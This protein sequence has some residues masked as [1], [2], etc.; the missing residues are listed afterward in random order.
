MSSTFQERMEVLRQAFAASLDDDVEEAWRLLRAGDRSAAAD[1]IHR[2]AG[3]AGTFGAPRVSEAAGHIEQLLPHGSAD[4][5]E[6]AFT[7]L[8]HASSAAAESQA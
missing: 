8:V 7:S 3:R 2:I 4:E 6:S 5:L 1:L